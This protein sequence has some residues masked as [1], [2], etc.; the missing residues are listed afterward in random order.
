MFFDVANAFNF[1][2]Q[3]IEINWKIYIFIES[4]KCFW[5]F[6]S[7][8]KVQSLCIYALIRAHSN[9][10]TFPFISFNAHSKKNS[11]FCDSWF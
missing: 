5:I 3:L 4:K 6:E 9:N 11:N 1:L 8:C 2:A 10:T 7:N